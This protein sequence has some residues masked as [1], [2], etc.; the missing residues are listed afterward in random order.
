M[1]SVAPQHSWAA[2]AEQYS[3][4]S[5]KINYYRESA[6][7]LAKRVLPDD[8]LC[9]CDL[10]CGSNQLLAEAIAKIVGPSSLLYCVDESSD[11]L[12]FALRQARTSSP[13]LFT[14]CKAEQIGSRFVD[15]FDYVLVNSAYWMFN[16]QDASKSIFDSLKL[17]GQLIF[18]IAEWDITLNVQTVQL[19]YDIIDGVLIEHGYLKKPHRGR[20]DKVTFASVE[21]ALKSVGFGDIT[22]SC[23][24][25]AMTLMDWKYFY[26]IEAIASKSIPHIAPA[27]A[28]EVLQIALDR[29]F[30]AGAIA[31]DVKWMTFIASKRGEVL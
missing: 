25:T 6:T 13:I 17:G 30:E 12:C 18:N 14:I 9:V 21:T 15:H 22:V 16:E 29:Q 27:S 3:R 7:L 23:H 26:S 11:M 20:A 2:S 4:I 19:R 24:A 8:N 1:Q 5:R 31:R 10:A 28:V